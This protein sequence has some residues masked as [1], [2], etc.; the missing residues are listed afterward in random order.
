MPLSHGQGQQLAQVRPAVTTPVTLFAVP[1]EGLHTEITLILI[2]NHGVGNVR[3][4]LYHDDD[5]TTFDADTGIAHISVSQNQPAGIFQAQH[6]GSGINIKPGGA[7]GIEVDSAN[8]I[9]CTIY[10]VTATIAYE[11]IRQS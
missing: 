5:G 10:G 6:P 7:L 9:T 3:I 2:D 1:A 4:S 8:D 11:R